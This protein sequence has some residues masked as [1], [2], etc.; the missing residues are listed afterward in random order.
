MAARAEAG[1]G[2]RTPRRLPWRSRC[3]IGHPRRTAELADQPGVV[4]NVHAIEAIDGEARVPPGIV[5]TIDCRNGPRPV[6]ALG[7]SEGC[8]DAVVVGNMRRSAGVEADGGI[9]TSVRTWVHHL[10]LPNP[11]D[12]GGVSQDAVAIV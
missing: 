4:G 2:Q 8:V 10:G 3:P 6:D 11:R 7:V 1:G 5:I 9:P 12:P